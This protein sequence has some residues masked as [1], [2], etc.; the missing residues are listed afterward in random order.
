MQDA[1]VTG[2]QGVSGYFTHSRHN[3][4][5][6]SVGPASLRSRLSIAHPTSSGV[7][8]PRP[9]STSVPATIRTMFHRKPDPLIRITIRRAPVP[10][11]PAPSPHAVISVT[12]HA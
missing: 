5:A 8:R 7:F 10:P 9:T 3:P 1:H 12:E 4:R 11:P 2:T 6:G